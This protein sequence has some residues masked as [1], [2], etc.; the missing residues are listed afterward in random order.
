[1]TDF[2]TDFENQL[3]SLSRITDLIGSGNECRLYPDVPR[4]GITLPFLV[5]AEVGGESE[6]YLNGNGAAGLA[7]AVVHLWA[8]GATR[9]S[10]NELS[11]IARIELLAQQDKRWNSSYITEIRV[12]SHRYYGVDSPLD[13][14]YAPRYW[15]R[16]PYD[17]WLTER[18][19]WPI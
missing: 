11:E 7:R 14:Q 8:F 10:A 15:V 3:R 5:Y 2:S 13:R 4:Q 9:Q 12:L 17:I 16:R 6:E 19:T 1:M 18:I